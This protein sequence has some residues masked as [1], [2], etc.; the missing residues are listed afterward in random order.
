MSERK[1]LCKEEFTN[2]EIVKENEQLK[3]QYR[4]EID[5]WRI[6]FVNME[7]NKEGWQHLATKYFNAL[8]DIKEYIAKNKILKY[9][10]DYSADNQYSLWEEDIENIVEII[11]EA[12]GSE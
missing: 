8:E 1:T 10:Y 3:E 7:E 12:L 4:K 9:K 5:F 11:S 2:C 6:Q